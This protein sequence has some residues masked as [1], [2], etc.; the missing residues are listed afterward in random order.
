MINIRREGIILGK[1]ERSFEN[2]GVMNPAVITRDNTV[3][4]LPGS[5]K[6]KLFHDRLLSVGRTS[7]NCSTERVAFGVAAI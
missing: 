1:T 4:M 2:E 3:H 6:G 5:Q 7:S